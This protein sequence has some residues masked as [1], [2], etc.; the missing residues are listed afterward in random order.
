MN[1]FKNKLEVRMRKAIWLPILI[2]LFGFSSILYAQSISE[3][4]SNGGGGQ[5]QPEQ[6][7]TIEQC[8]KNVDLTHPFR[9]VY[10]DWDYTGTDQTWAQLAAFLAGFAFYAFLLVLP[11]LAGTK[12]EDRQTVSTGLTALLICFFLFLVAMDM[13]SMSAADKMPVRQV[14]VSSFG[15]FIVNI[16]FLLMF[17]CLVWITRLYDSNGLM[18]SV[19]IGLFFFG[20]VYT[21]LMNFHSTADVVESVQNFRLNRIAGGPS[22]YSYSVHRDYY[23]WSRSSFIIVP[24]VIGLV[25]WKKGWTVS[26]FATRLKSFYILPLSALILGVYYL[27]I[28]YR[29]NWICVPTKESPS[30]IV[31]DIQ[32]LGSY[33]WF[34]ILPNLMLLATGLLL[35][36]LIMNLPERGKPDTASSV[37]L[38]GV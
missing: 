4:P 15:N 21:A 28:V 9:Q 25:S 20:L 29:V 16:G 18:E 38:Q 36:F 31:V 19:T 7:A 33:Y 37:R 24:A 23:Y 35:A 30:R 34:D 11:K 26:S 10:L 27:F 17:F 32:V 12:K 5:M 22:G 2:L 14:I 1:I 13:F 6:I 8:L 3:Q